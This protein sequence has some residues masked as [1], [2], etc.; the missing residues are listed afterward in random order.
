MKKKSTKADPAVDFQ[1][2]HIG[3]IDAVI[4]TS[5]PIDEAIKRLNIE[6]PTG[7]HS[8]W[9]YDGEMA[10]N[11]PCPDGQNKTHYRLFC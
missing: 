8:G 7:I 3:L 2:L 4:C 6:N 10:N 5:L 1:I 9:T 11:C